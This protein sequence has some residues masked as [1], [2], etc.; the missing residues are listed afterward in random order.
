MTAGR[1]CRIVADEFWAD[2]F[3]PDECWAGECPTQAPDARI[4]K[5]QAGLKAFGN[6]DM[7][8]DG[9]VGAQGGDQG[10]PV[11]VRAAADRPK[12]DELVY[13]KMREIG[14]TN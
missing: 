6:D 7:Q 4:V 8:L 1:R 5:I 3:R 13:V 12:P 14:L 2:E 11:A 9:V 10:I